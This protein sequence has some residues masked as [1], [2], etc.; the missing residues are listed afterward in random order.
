MGMGYALS[1]DAEFTGGDVIT[2]NF[3]TYHLPLF[4]QVP[5]IPERVLAGIKKSLG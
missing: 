1:E 5:M 2:K 3:D 4:S